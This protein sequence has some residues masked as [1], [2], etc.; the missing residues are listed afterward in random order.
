MDTATKYDALARFESRFSKQKQT[1][2]VHKRL[3]F[4]AADAGN[5]I[6]DLNDWLVKYFKLKK[7][8]R[9]LDIGCGTGKTLFTYSEDND[10]HGYGISL[11]QAEITLA[12]NA[13]KQL[14]MTDRCTFSVK[15]YDEPIPG[16]FD[17]MIAIE[18]LKHSKNLSVTLK[19]LA[20]SL[21]E[22]GILIVA[23]D[24]RTGILPKPF[25]QKLLLSHWSLVDVYSKADYCVSYG[26]TGFI[27]DQ[28]FDF[29]HLV[30]L[31]KSWWSLCLVYIIQ[32]FKLLIPFSEIRKI[33]SIFQAGFALEYYYKKGF[34][35]YRVLVFKK[36]GT[37]LSDEEMI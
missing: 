2:A 36:H 12:T 1:Y 7:S 28:E 35:E 21:N 17:Q 33:L 8:D 26:K 3:R 27:L 14:G 32:C 31:R 24:L 6:D 37:G 19:N 10:I 34:M 25:L 15:S 4:D 30:K 18:S 16:L 22:E 11:S 23:E 9:L 5:G 29:T 20:Q 13:A